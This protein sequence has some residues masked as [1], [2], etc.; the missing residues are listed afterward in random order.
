MSPTPP[1]ITLYRGFPSTT[2]YTW[3]PFVT[4]L[5]ARL[6]FSGISYTT[7]PGS[8][9]AAPKGKIPYIAIQNASGAV[10]TMADSTLITQRFIEEG[11]VS[12]LNAKLGAKDKVLDMGIRALLEERA[13]F[14]QSHEKWIDNYYTMR[15][16]ILA[17]LPYPAQVIVGYL[18]Y[19][20]QVQMLHGHGISRFSD[21]ERR[22]FKRE[23]W[24]EINALLVEAR[25]KRGGDD[26]P[27]WVLGGDGPSEADATLFGF[28]VGALICTA[29]PEMQG[30]VRGFPVV[31]EYARRIH[32]RLFPEY[33]VWGDA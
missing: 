4:K 17:S 13:Y 28:V 33:E 27:F 5:E 6:R 11:V 15:S 23:I 2:I 20:K 25:A 19:R 14:L 22:E 1:K 16:H 8:V 26:G 10:D 32:D 9:R 7:E 21:A 12:D 3:S 18:I 30:I 24:A 31:V 29:C